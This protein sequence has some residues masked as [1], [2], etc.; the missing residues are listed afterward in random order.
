MSRGHLISFACANATAPASIVESIPTSAARRRCQA[1]PGA[2]KYGVDWNAAFVAVAVDR[3]I[4]ATGAAH[5]AIATLAN[6]VDVTLRDGRMRDSRCA[7]TWP[8][9]NCIAVS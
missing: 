8:P 6:S 7:P 9:W 4:V 2:G 5:P 3:A 1:D